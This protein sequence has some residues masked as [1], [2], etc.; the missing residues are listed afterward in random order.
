MTLFMQR[1]SYGTT[2]NIFISDR[3]Y[4]SMDYELEQVYFLVVW[5]LVN[6]AQ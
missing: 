2:K 6:A 1:F 5:S 3:L 4:A